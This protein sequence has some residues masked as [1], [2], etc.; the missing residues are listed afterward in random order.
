MLRNAVALSEIF[1]ISW[2]TGKH[3]MEDDSKNHLKVRMI[4]F[5]AMV[6]YHP[7]SSKEQSSFHQFGQ[8]VLPRIFQACA[9]VAE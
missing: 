4:P 3:L 7:I 5:G 2:Q 6:E 1:K 9:L 8:K